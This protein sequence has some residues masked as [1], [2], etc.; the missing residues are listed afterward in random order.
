MTAKDLAY[1]R[2]SDDWESFISHYDTN[3]RIEVLVDD[4]LGVQAIGGKKCIDIG[5]GLGFFLAAI[6]KYN[7]SSLSGCD[8]SPKN[9]EKINKKMPQVQSYVADVLNLL[10]DLKNQSFDVAV[11]SEVIEHT[12]DP[13]LA[14]QNIS[15]II[16][17]GGLLALSVPNK[18][19]RWLLSLAMTFGLRRHYE[20]YENYVSPKDLKKW[21]EDEGFE[22]LRHE[23]VHTI[24]FQLFPKKWLRK[25]DQKLRNLNYSFALNLAVLAR[26]K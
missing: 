9:I 14:V 12:P 6:Q 4:F 8:L 11:C 5:C 10:E 3:R 18:R 17:S 24:P 16:S 1:D 15:K 21:L 7:P 26:K 23:G 20:G 22:I 2:I 25:L 13:K 19:W